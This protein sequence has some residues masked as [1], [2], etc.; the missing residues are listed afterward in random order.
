[1]SELMMPSVKYR[2]KTIYVAIVLVIAIAGSVF[3]KFNPF[4]LF[5][6]FSQVQRLLGEMM[7]PNFE[8]LWHNKG[9]A[10]A[11]GQTLAM[12]F[13]SCF[14]G[15][16]LAFVFALLA[17]NNTM[18]NKTIRLL[19]GGVLD[20][21]RIIPSLVFIIMFIIVVGLGAFSGMLAL[22]VITMSNFGKLFTDIIENTEH[23]PDEAIFSVGASRLQVIRYSLFP[24][25]L[26]AIIANCFYAFDVSIR[27]AIGL[28]IFGGGGI[29]YELFKAMQV[30]HYKDAFAI[31][32]IIGVLVILIEKL[33]DY[34]RGMVLGKKI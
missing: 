33:S 11:L 17:A 32:F 23:A 29:G 1:M 13:L 5:A 2:Q 9:I 4:E 22:V 12:A 28:G 8:L 19:A 7:P 21:L 20:L 31:I 26:P 24:Q 10:A 18:P 14:Y 27:A 16:L 6:D 15:T 30:M 34:L 3:V 25:I